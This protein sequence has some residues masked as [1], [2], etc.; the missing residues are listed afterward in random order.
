MKNKEVRGWVQ[1]LIWSIGNDLAATNHAYEKW[2]SIMRD[3]DLDAGFGQKLHNVDEIIT[4][5]TELRRAKMALL[6]NQFPDFDNKWH[7]ALKHAIEATV[8]MMEVDAA[9]Q[10]SDS[11]EDTIDDSKNLLYRSYSVLAMIMSQAFS[12]EF[13]ACWRC[14]SDQLN[15]DD[16]AQM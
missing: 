11:D 4:E 16:R 8:E 6:E 14:L 5:L 13:E 9:I 15:N 12:M 10:A 2:Y 1:D 3:S 7:C